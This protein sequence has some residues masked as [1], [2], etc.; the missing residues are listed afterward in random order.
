METNENLTEKLQFIG[1][2][3]DNIPAELKFLHPINFGM[4]KNYNEENYKIY[5]YINVDD[6]EIFLTPT[7]RLTEYTEKYAKALPLEAYLST[8]SEENIERN[9]EFLKLLKGL[10][11]DE[12]NELEQFQNKLNRSIPYLISYHK[13]YLWQIYYSDVSKKY[14]MLVPIKE[15]EATTLFYVIKNKIEHKGQKIFVPICYSE[16]S[17][18]YLSSDE[19]AEIEKFLCFFTK[20]WPL[21]HEVYDKNDNMSIQIVGKTILYDNLKSEYKISL[22][23]QGEAEDYYKL[24]KV[25][26]M[27]ETQ[28]SHYY[29]FKIKLDKKGALHFYH[30]EKEIN[31]RG[32]IAFIKSEYVQGLER[33]IKV[34][35]NK[36]NL[37]KEL[38]NLKALAK[39]LDED[40]FEK[41]KQISTFLE[42]KKTFFG[43]VK[44]FIKYKK[45]TIQIEKE[46]VFEKE[47]NSKLKY[48]ERTEIR[49]AYTLEELL[50]LYTN[51]LQE[52]NSTKDLELDI[53]A[54]RKRI[55]MLQVKIKNANLYIK[56]IDK[57]KKSIFEF[58]KF[59]NKDEAKALNEGVQETHQ[60]KKLKKVFN[61]DLDFEDLSKQLDKEARLLFSKDKTDSIFITTTNLISDLNRVVNGE[62]LLEE[63]LEKQKEE[64]KNSNTIRPFDIF[65]SSASS[66]DQIK[67]L[68]NIKHRE[69]EKNKFAILELRED[70]TIEE[71]TNKLQH[72]SN[73]IQSIM[74]L[75]KNSI[76]IP[77][78]KVGDIEEGFN[79]FYINPENALKHANG[80]E[81]YFYKIILKE[82]T[83]C[84]PLTNIMYY[85]NTNQTLPLGMNIEDG[86][87]IDTKIL[88]LELKDKENNYIIKALDDESKPQTLKINIQEYKI[89]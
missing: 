32:I 34:K 45:K 53:D 13:D 88:N 17:N 87:L 61:Y 79:I 81:I 28:L 42:C 76:E 4:H 33:I 30:N 68:G 59:T 19:I 74:R 52:S 22:E 58:W 62:N 39:K 55:E 46:R 56:E 57:H 3:F 71:Y 5:R 27:L 70:T 63:S 21:I 37:T 1:L 2:D 48:C 36:I 35:E 89:C 73:E 7:H 43:K 54:I 49:E 6:I 69:N 24:L 12:L 38:K 66:K 86:I 31:Y 85:N 18:K 15:T 50:M 72:I 25:L 80:K 51:L 8:D 29:K 77:I 26:F 64:L 75:F 65:G 47:E 84:I 67:T 16:Y 11:L 82:N 40:Y 23:N 83:N 9:I 78:Y 20:D 44:Y 10:K 14:F 41:E 60:T